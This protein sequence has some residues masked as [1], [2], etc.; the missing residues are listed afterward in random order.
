[1]KKINIKL[2]PKTEDFEIVLNALLQSG[3]DFWTD[4]GC[5]TIKLFLKDGSGFNLSLDIDGTWHLE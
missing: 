5:K 1:M 3:M 2:K 4:N